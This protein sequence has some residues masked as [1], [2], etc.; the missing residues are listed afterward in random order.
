[1]Q[2]K[3]PGAQIYKSTGAPGAELGSSFAGSGSI[4]GDISPLYVIDGVTSAIIASAPGLDRVTRSGGGGFAFATLE[5]PVNRIADLNPDEIEG[6][7]GPQRIICFGDLWI[8]GIR[9]RKS[10]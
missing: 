8:E 1:L 7:R 2:G 9:W 3:I 4:N 10:S 5:D 6:H